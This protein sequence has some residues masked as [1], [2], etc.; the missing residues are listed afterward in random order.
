[1]W[2]HNDVGDGDGDGVGTIGDTVVDAVG[3]AVKQHVSLQ[4]WETIGRLQLP[5]LASSAQCAAGITS[6]YIRSPV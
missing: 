4:F 5:S 6:A 2:G 3:D 1:V